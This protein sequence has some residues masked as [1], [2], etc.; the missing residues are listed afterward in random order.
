MIK[1]IKLLLNKKLKGFEELLTQEEVFGKD[2]LDNQ[3]PLEKP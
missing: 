3:I 1:S 2:K